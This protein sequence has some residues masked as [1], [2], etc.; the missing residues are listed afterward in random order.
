MFLEDLPETGQ[1]PHKN[2]FEMLTENLWDLESGITPVI[3]YTKWFL[4]I[5]WYVQYCI[6]I[7]PK[8]LTHSWLRFWVEESALKNFPFSFSAPQRLYWWLRVDSIRAIDV[9]SSISFN[10]VC[11]SAVTL[12]LLQVASVHLSSRNH[13]SA[14]LQLHII[15]SKFSLYIIIH[16]H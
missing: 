4:E 7:T 2:C 11:N 3:F 14:T 5:H 15:S 16:I 1:R 10:S 6:Q 12:T 8:N 13:H 9:T